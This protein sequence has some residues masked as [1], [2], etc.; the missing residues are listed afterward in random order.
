MSEAI[1]DRGD[2]DPRDA[3][4]SLVASKT[5][6]HRH[7]HRTWDG[8]WPVRGREIKILLPALACVIGVFTLIGLTYTKWMA[9]NA[10]T[11][12]DERI[13][14][15]AANNRTHFLNQ[16]A[17]WVV[18]P[19]NTYT[20]IAISLVICLFLLWKYRRWYEPVYV[21]LPLVFE[22]SAFII[23]T[24][25]V[26]R[27]RPP[28]ERLLSSSIVSSYPSGHA[29]A[30]TVYAAVAIIVF[31]HTRS[32]WGRSLAVLL[33]VLLPLSVGWV[34]IYQGM[35]FFTDVIAGMVLG[36]VSLL[37]THHV[38]KRQE[39]DDLVPLRLGDTVAVEQGAAQ[40]TS[41]Q[42]AS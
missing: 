26:R 17:P 21:A 36:I 4:P 33:A 35:H 7:D 3:R 25:I 19:A 42:M 41:P 30:T 27:D 8:H 14:E 39:P 29:A 13:A 15:A 10:V 31:R 9:P 23:T 6:P 18:F 5:E 2:G 22:A 38:L 16:I 34:R 28:V 11:R 12:F 24:E 32:A 37:I 20:K 1:L 40:E